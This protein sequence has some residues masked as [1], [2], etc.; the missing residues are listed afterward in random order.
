MESRFGP[1]PDRAE[2]VMANYKTAVRTPMSVEEAFAYMADLRNFAHWDPGVKK[3]VQVSG[4]GPGM[5]A[6]YDVTVSSGPKDLEMR[7]ETVE[8]EEP[9]RALVRAETRLLTS[10]D[11]V[12]VTPDGEGSIVTYE[13]ELTLKG[14]AGLFDPVLGL[15]FDRI[16]DRAAAGLRNALDGSEVDA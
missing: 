3:S 11:E 2:W 5:D 4:D 15:V 8:F 7:Y 10:V 6:A 13:A 9:S 1:V 16:G 14:P 12:T